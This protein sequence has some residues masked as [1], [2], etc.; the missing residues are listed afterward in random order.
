MELLT[1]R[2]EDGMYTFT[3]P[4]ILSLLWRMSQGRVG[5]HYSSPVLSCAHTGIATGISGRA[6]VCDW[7]SDA[8]MSA[9]V[10]QLAAVRVPLSGPASSRPLTQ[11]LGRNGR[12]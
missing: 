7:L 4:P 1:L 12:R 11:P 10:V 3:M 2:Q 5:E 9:P 8:V 6:E